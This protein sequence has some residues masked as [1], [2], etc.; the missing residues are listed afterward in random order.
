M[1]R[2]FDLKTLKC[3]KEI[4]AH[5]DAVSAVLPQTSKNL[6]F[7]GSHDGA[8]RAWDIRNYQCS[9]DSMVHRRKYDEGVNV[10]VNG[11][12]FVAS[13]GADCLVKILQDS[14]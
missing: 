8:L 2:F 9:F 5:T 10:L 6:V 1:I 12:N 14:Q 4:V 13:G 7:S 3:I 11:D